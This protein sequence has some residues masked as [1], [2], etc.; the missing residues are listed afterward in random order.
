MDIKKLLGN[1]D[2]KT[3]ITSLLKKTS[4]N[5]LKIGEI[6]SNCK[7]KVQSWKTVDGTKFE[8]AKAMYD[9]LIESL[10]FKKETA[11]KFIQIYDDPLLKK[12]LDIC[13][14]AYTT[15]YSIVTKK[16]DQEQWDYLRENG[17]HSYSSFDKVNEVLSQ[18]QKSKLPKETPSSETKED[19]ASNTETTSEETTSTEDTT[20]T[21]SEESS[22]ASD[23]EEDTS[24]DLSKN[25]PEVPV[26]SN[27]QT[28]FLEVKIVPSNLSDED[29]KKLQDL[30]KYVE[31]LGFTDPN[32]VVATVNNTFITDEKTFE[33]AA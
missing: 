11:N 3:Q 15:M 33:I 17:I 5:Q 20:S 27:M 7:D 31:T 24:S 6:L 28:T 2:P 21:T 13:P 1:G 25:A 10:P 23:K 32:K 14:V 9:E 12:N 19:D 30:C 22:E 8:L 26:V 29:K 16:I 4:E 18:Y